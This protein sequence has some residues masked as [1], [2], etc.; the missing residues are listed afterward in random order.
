MLHQSLQEKGRSLPRQDRVVITRPRQRSLPFIVAE[1]PSEAHLTRN[2]ALY[3]I[4]LFGGA[5]LAVVWTV[6]MLVKYLH[7]I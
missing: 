4:P 5:L 7:L 6:M 1:T 3:S 2:Y